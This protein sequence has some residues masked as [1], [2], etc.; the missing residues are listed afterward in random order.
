MTLQIKVITFYVFY[1]LCLT[2]ITGCKLQTTGFTL[3]S[4][5]TKYTAHS[6]DLPSIIGSE[7]KVINTIVKQG[8]LLVKSIKTDTSFFTGVD[9]ATGKIL[10]NKTDP[11][12]DYVST[13]F[14]I[15][16]DNIFS[17]SELKPSDIFITDIKTSNV[18]S[19]VVHFEKAIG[20]GDIVLNQSQIFLINDVWGVGVINQKD[21]SK[22]IFHNSGEIGL[23]NPQSSTLS[24][25]V[26]SSLNLLSGHVIANNTIQLYAITN[27]DSIKWRYVIKQNSKREAVS[28]L[29][30]SNLFVVKY[31][32]TLV[33]LNKNDGKE[34]WHKA[35]NS[36][37]N[38]IYKW[39]DKVLGYCLVNPK[40]IYPDND[41]FEYKVDLKLFDCNTGKE[42]WSIKTNSI[43]VPH[44]GIC[45]NRLLLS[46]NRTFTA[47]SLDSGRI[48]K[49]IS[50]SKKEKNNYAFD[51]ISDMITSEHYLKSYDGKFYW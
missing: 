3:S 9:L 15:N 31:D 45:N 10:F 13:A 24:F 42:L 2:N 30:F 23:V 29:N 4:D 40:G 7:Y 39:Q 16:G 46:D 48:I 49:K 34:I 17:L 5:L 12:N 37:I 38:E 21:F 41:D 33:G 47:F 51:M 44:L 35:L 19:I 6:L 43:N 22:V 14:D 50:F 8:V 28:I 25:P 18:Q 26:D 20:P 36:S 1:L 32:S 11:S 27:Q